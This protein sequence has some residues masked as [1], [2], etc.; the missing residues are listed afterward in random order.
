MKKY[1]AKNKEKIAITV[2]AYSKKNSEKIAG[3]LASYYDK[4]RDSI[5]ERQKDKKEDIAQVRRVY[6]KSA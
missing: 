3:Y 2:K 6:K 5:L 4:N 1:R